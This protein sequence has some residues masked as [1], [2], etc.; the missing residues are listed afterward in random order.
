MRFVAWVGGLV[1]VA[2]VGAALASTARP[3]V[4]G[5]SPLLVAQRQGSEAGQGLSL[6]GDLFP[7]PSPTPPAVKSASSKPPA[8]SAPVPTKA[9]ARPSVVVSSRQQALINQDRAA[10]HLAPLTW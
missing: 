10:Y 6:P 7:S 4:N 3:S 9:P 2:V 1:L 5:G 8:R